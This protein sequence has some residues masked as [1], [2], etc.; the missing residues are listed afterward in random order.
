M[1]HCIMSIKL[2]T[3]I[4]FLIPATCFANKDN[5]LVLDPK[6]SHVKSNRSHLVISTTDDESLSMEIC[7]NYTNNYRDVS[8]IAHNLN[9]LL[10]LAAGKNQLI[11][12]YPMRTNKD[13][14]DDE[15]KLIYANQLF[16]SFTP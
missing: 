1:L 4:L 6:L 14:C 13:A 16:E 12:F 11:K 2:L 8:D 5:F 3:L 10:T 9:G 7:P 15:Q